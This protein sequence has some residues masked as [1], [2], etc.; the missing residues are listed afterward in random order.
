MTCEF[1]RSS[2]LMQ[3]AS[4]DSYGNDGARKSPSIKMNTRAKPLE[5][6]LEVCSAHLRNYEDGD[7]RL[8]GCKRALGILDPRI[9]NKVFSVIGWCL[10][11][12]IDADRSKARFLSATQ[13]ARPSVYRHKTSPTGKSLRI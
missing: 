12:A 10:P 1:L 4:S 5:W 13:E 2:A 11:L 3:A 8:M 9:Q 6:S 7:G